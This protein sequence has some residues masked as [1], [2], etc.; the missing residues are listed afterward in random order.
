MASDFDLE[1]D[2]APGTATTTRIPDAVWI[3]RPRPAPRSAARAAKAIA[4]AVALGLVALAATHT[5]TERLAVVPSAL[6]G[7]DAADAVG[8]GPSGYFPDRFDQR[9]LPLAEQPSTF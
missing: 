4:A 3:N 9:R 1:D 7:T 6:A 2:D 5:V 8:N